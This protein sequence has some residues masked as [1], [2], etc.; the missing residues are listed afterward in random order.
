MTAFLE[1][2]RPKGKTLVRVAPAL[3]AAAAFALTTAWTA[4][5][6][7]GAAPFYDWQG[8]SAKDISAAQKI[9]WAAV[10]CALSFTSALLLYTTRSTWTPVRSLGRYVG[11]PQKVLVICLSTPDLSH[12]GFDLGG[13]IKIDFHDKE[14]SPAPSVAHFPVGNIKDDI[15]SK[16][17]VG[18]KRVNWQQSLRAIHFHASTLEHLVVVPSLS[19]PREP[20][21]EDY[22]K[23]FRKLLAHYLA[24]PDWRS[25][26]TVTIRPP[27][28][29][30]DFEKLH[31]A[32]IDVIKFAKDKN[33]TESDIVFDITAGQKVASVAAAIVTLTTR[34]D[35]QYV[36]TF[37]DKG[38]APE[39][40]TYAVVAES[41][42]N[43]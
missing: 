28:D 33:F 9:G 42:P 12:M 7:K 30:E 10:L 40:I 13:G 38:R 14:I 8:L 25:K 1:W 36:Q 35:F 24:Q 34:A 39:I 21:S 18:D 26:F 22:D 20:G 4:D 37:K 6:V 11:K 5:G 19:K 23:P 43:M 17:P 29:Y 2:W 27:V 15:Q 16:S 41:P 32:F 31:T 3:V